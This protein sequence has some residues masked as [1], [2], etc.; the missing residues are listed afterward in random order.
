MLTTSPYLK[1]FVGEKR[2]V[3]HCFLS[4]HV[5]TKTWWGK[6]TGRR[7][8]WCHLRSTH[9]EILLQETTARSTM[10]VTYNSNGKVKLQILYESWCPVLSSVCN[11]ST[12]QRLVRA[13]PINI[14][15]LSL[16][17]LC[18]ETLSFTPRAASRSFSS[19]INFTFVSGLENREKLEASVS[20]ATSGISQ[21][22]GF[23]ACRCVQ[24]S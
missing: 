9:R 24:S 5:S 4:L 20:S 18:Q 1:V 19:L 16:Y 21:S 12:L 11:I 17:S 15:A 8:R 23:S 7:R 3:H 6:L 22:A 10:L 2:T 13:L 14:Q